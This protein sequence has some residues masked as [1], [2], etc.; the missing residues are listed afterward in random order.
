M[1]VDLGRVWKALNR[2]EDATAALLAASR[3]GEPRAAEMARELLPERYPFVSE[4]RRA[5]S[6]I[7]TI[8]AAPR[9]GLPAAPHGPPAEAE[10]EFALPSATRPTICWPPL[11]SASCSTRAATERGAM[12]LFDRVLA[13]KDD[14][15]ANRVR[16]VLHMPQVLNRAPTRSP[17]PSTPR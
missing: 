17:P 12:P 5:L 8:R 13:G 15:L 3:G 7:P 14:D 16:A 9:I 6:S 4:F 1:L 10:A 2:P 11:N